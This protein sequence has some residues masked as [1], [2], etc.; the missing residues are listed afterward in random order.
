M[1]C[2]ATLNS[3][4]KS[5]NKKQDQETQEPIEQEQ[6]T[7]RNLVE[8]S[9]IPGIVILTIALV[10]LI[11]IQRKVMTTGTVILGNI[12]NSTLNTGILICIIGIIVFACVKFWKR[13]K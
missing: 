4:M 2:Q 7:K 3:K 5:K 8:K 12:T 9:A 6:V 1:A 13:N 10:F 11:F